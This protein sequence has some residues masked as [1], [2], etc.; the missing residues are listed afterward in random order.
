MGTSK[1]GFPV[2][3]VSELEEYVKNNKID[4]AVIT[5]P[6]EVAPEMAEKLAAYGIKGLWNFTSAELD[7]TKYGVEAENVHLG[8]S[9]MTLCYK[10][11]NKD[12]EE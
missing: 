11:T 4:I 6:R 3:D 12:R 1:Y 2:F 9:L 10:V 5:V 8:D 7:V